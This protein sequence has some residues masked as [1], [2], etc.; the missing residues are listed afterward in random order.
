MIIREAKSEDIKQI[1]IVRN[2]VRENTL[3]DP[4]LVT[5]EDCEEFINKR[6]KGWVCEIDQKIVGFAIVDLK[7]HNI[8]ALFLKPE[9]EKRGIGRKLH[10]VMLDWYFSRTTETVWLG[11]AFNTRAEMFYRKAGW[12]EAGLHG[13]KEIKFEMSWDDYSNFK[14]T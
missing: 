9:F 6:G 12:K 10:K 8:W 1:Q 4:G 5:D 7:E 2:S 3:S 14:S 13:T 11:T